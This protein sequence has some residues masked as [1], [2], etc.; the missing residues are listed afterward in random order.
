[1]RYSEELKEQLE[2]AYQQSAQ[3]IDAFDGDDAPKA[4]VLMID[5]NTTLEQI[6]SNYDRL[7][8][9]LDA[10]STISDAD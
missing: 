8:R 10:I 6:L 2:Q 3:A 1:M 7:M 5:V 4:Y 9:I